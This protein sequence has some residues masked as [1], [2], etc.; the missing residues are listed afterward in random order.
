MWEI[1]GQSCSLIAPG[2][3]IF[4]R[5]LIFDLSLF[6]NADVVTIKDEASKGPFLYY[7]RVFW[8]SF[9]PPTHLRKDIFTR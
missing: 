8:G 6:T 2:F 7:V 4:F 3:T 9:E 1:L 5:C